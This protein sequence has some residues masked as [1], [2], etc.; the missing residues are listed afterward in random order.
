MSIYL[1]AIVVYLSLND[2]TTSE[3][4]HHDVYQAHQGYQVLV[5]KCNFNLLVMLKGLR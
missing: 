5:K 4:N 1:I 2:H 3:H